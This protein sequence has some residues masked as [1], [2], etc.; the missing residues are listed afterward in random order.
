MPPILWCPSSRARIGPWD[1]RRSAS[2]RATASCAGRLFRPDAGGEALPC[3][4]MACG[5]SCVR[6]QGLDAFAERLAGAGFAALAFDYR[7]FGESPRRAALADGCAPASARTGAPPSP[8]LAPSA[9]VD[10]DPDR[11][12][13]LLAGD[14]AHPGAGG[15]TASRSAALVCVAPVLSGRRSLLHIGG[16]GHVARLTVAGGRDMAREL[17]GAAPYR[18]PAA[19]APGSSAVINSPDAV[20]GFAAIT[21]P[22]STWRNE[23][24]ARVALAPPY[25]LRERCAGSPVPPSTASSRRTTSTRRRSAGGRKARPARRAARIPRRPLRPLRQH[26][27]QE[28]SSSPTRIESRRHLRSQQLAIQA[29]LAETFSPSVSSISSTRTNLTRGRPWGSPRPTSAWSIACQ[30]SKLT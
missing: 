29:G 14:G 11:D 21:P 30:S 17:R 26:N 7:H 1:G 10:P 23:V 27:L 24:C 8:A 12:V 2:R 28:R 19:G 3:V 4:V 16:P 13:G 9:E 18:V 25:S 6:D 22:D 5:F 20:P 15:S